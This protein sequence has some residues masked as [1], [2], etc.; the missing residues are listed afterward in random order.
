MKKS[1]ADA[2]LAMNTNPTWMKKLNDLGI[3]GFTTPEYGLYGDMED[4][5]KT[6]EK[7]SLAAAYY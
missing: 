6:V 1:I 4:L 3:K 2:L 7:L 5:L